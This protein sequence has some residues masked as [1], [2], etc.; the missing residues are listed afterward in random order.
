MCWLQIP[1]HPWCNC[2]DPGAR[3]KDGKLLCPHHIQFRDDTGPIAALNYFQRKAV[4]DGIRAVPRPAAAWV[5]CASYWHVFPRPG[6]EQFCAETIRRAPHGHKTFAEW[7]GLCRHCGQAG[8]AGV[9]MRLV[10]L[11]ERQGTEAIA[12]DGA[13]EGW[14]EV[15]PC[16]GYCLPDGRELDQELQERIW[17]S[18][19]SPRARGEGV[20]VDL[21][22]RRVHGRWRIVPDESVV[23]L[24]PNAG[25]P[26]PPKPTLVGATAKGAAQVAAAGWKGLTKAVSGF[27]G[28]KF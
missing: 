6:S 4:R 11:R 17:Q 24:I 13:A 19:H 10:P 21:V 3:D 28:T 12:L 14:E 1:Q 9:A 18:V 7:D 22:E 16:A 8:Q 5:H 2:P 20:F 23:Y 15:I 27:V 26:N 25:R